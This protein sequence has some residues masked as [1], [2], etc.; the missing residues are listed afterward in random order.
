M[1]PDPA[2]WLSLHTHFDRFLLHVI[3]LTMRE[4][5]LAFRSAENKGAGRMELVRWAY[6]V[7]ALDL[8][9]DR[10]PYRISQHGP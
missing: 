1:F 7:G 6:H 9:C 3:G 10:A 4:G 5:A 8:G 2:S